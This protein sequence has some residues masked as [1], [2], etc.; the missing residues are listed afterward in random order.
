M[1]ASGECLYSEEMLRS[2]RIL[3]NTKINI[4]SSLTNLAQYWPTFNIPTFL[5]SFRLMHIMD[6]T[7]GL[8]S[9]IEAETKDNDNHNCSNYNYLNKTI[10]PGQGRE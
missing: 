2:I 4:S 3:S 8:C 10:Q 6:G 9:Y 5:F 1:S 7:C